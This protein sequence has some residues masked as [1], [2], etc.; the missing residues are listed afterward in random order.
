MAQA[1]ETAGSD[2]PYTLLDIG[3]YL[4]MHGYNW[5]WVGFVLMISSLAL[6]IVLDFIVSALSYPGA[7]R[8]AAWERKP[9]Y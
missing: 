3:L 8:L 7:I 1:Q 2:A 9:S 6:T 4:T 5:F